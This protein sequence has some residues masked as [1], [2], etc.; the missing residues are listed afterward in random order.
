ML[1]RCEKYPF[2][3]GLLFSYIFDTVKFCRLS[4]KG[5]SMKEQ[6]KELE[7]KMKA[8]EKDIEADLPAIE[9]DVQLKFYFIYMFFQQ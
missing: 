3:A 8:Y 2:S 9:V 7:E 5:E 1:Q 4:R 6:F